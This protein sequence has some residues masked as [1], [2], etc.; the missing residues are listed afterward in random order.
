[1]E[2]SLNLE[3]EL[4]KLFKERKYSQIILEITTKTQE[5]QRSASLLTL[6]GICRISNNKNDKDVVSQAIEDFKNAYLKEK[7][8][9]NG[10]NGLVNFI[11]ASV[12]LRD[13]KKSNENFEK[14]IDYYN[15][16]DESFLNKREINAAMLMVYKR[17]ND[18]ERMIFHLEKV[19]KSKDVMVVDLCNYGYWR[20]FDKNWKQI[21]FLNYGKSLDGKLRKYKENVLLKISD[22]NEKKIKIG[23][24]SADIKNGHSITYFLRTVLSNYDKE[25]FEILLFL[26]REK[27]DE[28]VNE[29]KNLVSKTINITKLTSIQAI[30]SIRN[31]KLDIMVDLMGYTSEQRIVLFKNRVAKKQVLWMGYCNTTGIK[32]MDY[33]ISDPNL[34]YPEEEKHYSEKIIYLPQIWNSHCGY[35]FPRS[36]SETPFQKNKHVTFGSFNNFSKITS[37]VVKVWSQIL[38][39]VPNSKLILKSSLKQHMTTRLENL[40]QIEG[41]L[42]SVVFDNNQESFKDHM[43]LYKKIDIALDTFPYNGVTTSFEAIWMGVPVISMQGYNFNSRCG[44]S[45]NKNLNLESLIAKNSKE[46]VSIAKNLSTNLDELISI[47]KK[48][49]DNAEKSALFD[50]KKFSV[51]FY[52]SLQKLIN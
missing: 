23:F 25:K 45:I 18:S 7:K 39:D 47:R 37:D 32:N 48:I 46:Y 28:T 35:D 5:N 19:I 36:K 50:T 24:I 31:F 30:N 15:S 11:V 33:L 14:I 8:T 12:I 20:C 38:K 21:D 27:E 40:F 17:M 41:V 13:L 22:E 49:F 42:G 3:L 6:L 44:E 9:I 2:S 10:F 16:L 1:M 43:N 26:N 29:F 34:I 4:Q 51:H 52:Q